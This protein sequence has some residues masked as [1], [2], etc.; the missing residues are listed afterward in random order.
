MRVPILIGVV[1]AALGGVV[2]TPS[3]AAQPVGSFQASCQGLQVSA[4]ALTANCRD[5]RGNYHVSSI[6]YPS[7]KGDIANNDGVLVCNGATATVQQPRD[8]GQDRGGGPPPGGYDQGRAD[9]GGNFGQ[10]GY[11]QPGYSQP[12]YSQPG[13]SQPGYGQPGYAQP[14]YGDRGHGDD[15]GFGDRQAKGVY[16]QFAGLERHIDAAIRDGVRDDLI[17]R[18]DAHD[19]MRQLRDIQARERREY[20]VHGWNLPFDDQRRI[21]TDLRRLDRLVDQTR[22]EP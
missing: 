9:R 4:G 10:P 7:C 17:A 3:F 5:R 13:Y 15:G 2:A 14:G 22:Q 8:G 12:G 16:P 1:A 19:M 18:D 21:E 20:Q 11:S 6:A